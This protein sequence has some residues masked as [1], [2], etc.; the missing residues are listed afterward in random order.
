MF[1]RGHNDETIG[2]TMETIGDNIKE[3]ISIDEIIESKIKACQR[4]NGR[5][6][7]STSKRLRE[8]Y[9]DYQVTTVIK[10]L[11]KRKQRGNKYQEKE[12][13]EIM[14]LISQLTKTKDRTRTQ[15]SN[16]MSL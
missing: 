5:C 11:N 1:R 2:D 13:S 15:S 3:T 12:S 9:G 4:E 6:M 10:R 7:G 14:N 8:R 16:F